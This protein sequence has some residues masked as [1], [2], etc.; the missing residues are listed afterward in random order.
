MEVTVLSIDHENPGFFPKTGW[1]ST[2]WHPSDLLFS[3]QK[4]VD[5]GGNLWLFMPSRSEVN[6]KT[7]QFASDVGGA[8]LRNTAEQKHGEELQ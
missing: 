1:A 4:H 8:T 3:A 7:P 5:V 6:P 2:K